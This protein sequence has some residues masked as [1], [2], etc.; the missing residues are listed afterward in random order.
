MDWKFI[1]F[2]PFADTK[3]LHHS[4]LTV[5]IT[6]ID[7]CIDVSRSVKS[8]EFE[9][10]CVFFV[11]FCL[12]LTLW[13]K[14]TDFCRHNICHAIVSMNVLMHIDWVQV[15]WSTTTTI[16]AA[17]MWKT[18]EKWKIWTLSKTEKRRI[19][20]ESADEWAQIHWVIIFI[21]DQGCVCVI[22]IYTKYTEHKVVYRQVTQSVVMDTT[23]LT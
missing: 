4:L 3:Q 12:L 15:K 21:A 20:E 7:K 13:M 8:S 19:Y 9:C 22:H 16:S 2:F 6:F 17:T 11:I 23:V 18:R 10:R 14:W 1:E 5:F